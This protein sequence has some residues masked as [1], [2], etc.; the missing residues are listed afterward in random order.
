MMQLYTYISYIELC[1]YHF[2]KRID[3]LY[4]TKYTVYNDVFF[5]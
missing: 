5:G 1:M 3:N 2:E 4:Y